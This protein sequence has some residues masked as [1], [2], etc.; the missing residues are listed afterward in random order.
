MRYNH[1]VVMDEIAAVAKMKAPIDTAALR[2]SIYVVG[3]WGSGY[4]QAVA[5][6]RA[7][8]PLLDDRNQIGPP[9]VLT[10]TRASKGV[11]LAAIDIPLAYAIFVHNGY[12]HIL[13]EKVI[14]P[15][16]FLLE[17][18]LQVWNSNRFLEMCKADFQRLMSH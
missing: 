1:K 17:A 15:N 4:S 12:Y 6:A 9:L 10:D 2:E 14:P 5:S 18:F 3:P 13:A 7:A 11:W 16:P 8:S